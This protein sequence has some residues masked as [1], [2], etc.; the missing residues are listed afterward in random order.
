MEVEKLQVVC[1][2]FHKM[3]SNFV[4]GKYVIHTEQHIQSFHVHVNP[5]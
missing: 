3:A 5:I 4:A 2:P 1:S